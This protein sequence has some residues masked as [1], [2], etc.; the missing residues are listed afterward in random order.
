MTDTLVD[1]PSRGFEMAEFM[2]RCVAA[3]GRRGSGT[4]AQKT[5]R[6]G[7]VDW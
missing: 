6:P 2:R 5:K 1:K 4:C 3:H 7:V